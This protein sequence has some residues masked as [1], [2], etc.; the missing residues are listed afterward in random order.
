[1]CRIAQIDVNRENGYTVTKKDVD[2]LN[3]YNKFS[4]SKS[5]AV[6][7]FIGYCIK[8]GKA[9]TF[10][11]ETSTAT[12]SS[13]EIPNE[14]SALL[15]PTIVSLLSTI[16][17]EKFKMYVDDN[18]VSFE[19]TNIRIDGT[20]MED[21][22]KYPTDQLDATINAEQVFT[23]VVKVNKTELNNVLDRIS[24]FVEGDDEGFIGLSFVNDGILISSKK[25]SGVEKV[26][27]TE[28]K[29]ETP[30]T[31]Q[32][33]IRD[34]KGALGT[35]VGETITISFGDQIGLRIEEN[36]VYH[37]ISQGNDDVEDEEQEE[38]EQEETNI[39]TEL[40]VIDE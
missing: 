36:G 20:L 40:E 11:S 26:A 35:I 32:I 14:I 21:L 10:N 1:M 39:T 27:Y 5:I 31:K 8:N 22:D 37:I 38:V 18:K 3:Q 15:P 30:I 28:G 9:Y 2:K 17:D 29:L 13:L 34:L 25:S 6:P 33:D 19:S 12:V 24:I 16:K 7:Y 23:N 4:V